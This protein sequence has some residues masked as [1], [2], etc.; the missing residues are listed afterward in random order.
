MLNV[1][2]AL[3]FHPAPPM[4]PHGSNLL[5]VGQLL[6]G[7]PVPLQG[8]H[9]VCSWFLQV[10]HTVCLWFLQAHCL[11]LVWG[12]EMPARLSVWF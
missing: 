7:L 5:P 9:T 10:H 6:Q 2:L 12:P 4:G 3:A 8:I 1:C 11:G